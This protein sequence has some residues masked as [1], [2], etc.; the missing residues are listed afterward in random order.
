MDYSRF[1]ASAGPVIGR[2]CITF[3]SAEILRNIYFLI[4]FARIRIVENCL[5]VL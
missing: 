4:K 1:I 3:R 5:P 2:L